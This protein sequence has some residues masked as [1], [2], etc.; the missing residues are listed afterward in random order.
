MGDDDS[1]VF[2]NMVICITRSDSTN[3]SALTTP[4]VYTN[5]WSSWQVARET[6][7]IWRDWWCDVPEQ[8]REPTLDVSEDEPEVGL[9]VD[10]GFANVN[11]LDKIRDSAEPERSL[12]AQSLSVGKIIHQATIGLSRYAACFSNAERHQPA[13]HCYQ[14]RSVDLDVFRVV[15]AHEERTKRVGTRAVFNSVTM[16]F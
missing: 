4:S 1:Q 10:S 8:E 12:H 13:Q 9:D 6:G 16:V 2:Q 3:R 14:W 11:G 15:L 5:R 7:R